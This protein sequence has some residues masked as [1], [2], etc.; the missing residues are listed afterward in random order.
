LDAFGRSVPSIDESLAD[1]AKYRARKKK[2]LE[3]IENKKKTGEPQGEIA[4]PSFFGSKLESTVFPGLV[5][6]SFEEKPPSS[7]QT[8][9]RPPGLASPVKANIDAMPKISYPPFDS[10]NPGF[11]TT[12]FQGTYLPN[13]NPNQTGI[14][15]SF[16]QGNHQIGNLVRPLQVAQ[17]PYMSSNSWA[18]V[19][20]THGYPTFQNFADYNTYNTQANSMFALPPVDYSSLMEHSRQLINPQQQ[21]GQFMH[22]HRGN[23]N[24]PTASRGRRRQR[25]ENR[26]RSQQLSRESSASHQGPSTQNHNTARESE[27]DGKQ[28]AR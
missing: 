2:W 16:N 20:V 19:T 3:E 15:Q 26:G 24:N 22:S 28:S 10:S 11:L 1:F 6:P 23:E 17:P 8:P 18:N 4:R 12:G 5:S 7:T 9:A 14:S 27:N 21:S 25:Q 13:I